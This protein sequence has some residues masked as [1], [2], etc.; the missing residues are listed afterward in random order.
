MIANLVNKLKGNPGAEKNL[1]KMSS[2]IR[3]D[4]NKSFEGDNSAYGKE[5][6]S[7]NDPQPPKDASPKEKMEFQ[8][9]HYMKLEEQAKSKEAASLPDE[10]KQTLAAKMAKAAVPVASIAAANLGLYILTSLITKKANPEMLGMMIGGA[11]KATVVDTGVALG[12]D[13]LDASLPE[14]GSV[15]RIAGEALVSLIV[16]GPLAGM[17]ALG[18]GYLDSKTASAAKEHT[19]KAKDNADKLVEKQK[20]GGDKK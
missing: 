16:G 12:G 18:L 1:E 7:N 3:S 11:I 9:M 6:R 5:I 13:A 4:L 14:K 17:G 2:G 10:E 15:P 20:Q 19:T 8:T